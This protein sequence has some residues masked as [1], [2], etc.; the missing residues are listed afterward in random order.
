M[1]YSPGGHQELDT[2]EKLSNMNT[3]LYVSFTITSES[4]LFYLSSLSCFYIEDFESQTF[5]PQI[6]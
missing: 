1:S 5:Q 6:L 3:S 4:V 2:A